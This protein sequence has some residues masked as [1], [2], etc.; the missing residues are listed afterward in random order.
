MK[1]ILIGRSPDNDIVIND[2]Y[3]SRRHCTLNIYDDGRVSIQDLGSKTG[4]YVNGKKI[5]TEYF[6]QPR[7]QVKIG[8][9]LLPW[10]TYVKTYGQ[11]LFS[12]SVTPGRTPAKKLHLF[13]KRR[14][15]TSAPN[16]N[17][18]YGAA[19]T[20]L[21]AAAA[22]F[23]F[24]FHPAYTFD[25]NFDSLN[26]EA[27]D[28][29]QTSDDGFVVTGYSVED[30]EGRYETKAFLAKTDKK[31]QTE[32]IRLYPESDEDREYNFHALARGNVKNEFLVGGE[33]TRLISNDELVTVKEKI[34]PVLFKVNNEGKTVWKKNFSS[35]SPGIVEGIL[36]VRDGYLIVILSEE[37][38]VV[39]KI[40][41]N[42]N[43]VWKKKSGPADF[44]LAGIKSPAKNT[45]MLLGTAHHSPY[46][47]LMDENGNKRWSKSFEKN[48]DGFMKDVIA[49]KNGFTL[50]GM[51]ETRQKSSQFMVLK[52]RPDGTLIKK[53][54]YGGEEEEF[55]AGIVRHRKG[56]IL[57]GTTKSEGEGKGDGIII[58]IDREGKEMWTKTYGGE[59]EDGFVKLIK[60]RDGN[61]AACGVNSSKNE[62]E[63]N[64]WLI[65]FNK[66]GEIKH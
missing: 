21:A 15:R 17:I 33:E 18:L 47:I 13:K 23:L 27:H 38:P 14:L 56:Y 60:T 37:K 51:R 48:H 16:R 44:Q 31:G 34:T 12:T 64:P 4:T 54:F 35:I 26:G 6:L 29:I 7:D 41:E 39:I 40:E 9:T 42:G 65:K 22:Y 28:L 66:K 24:F 3:V 57:G 53:Y 49:D 10:P 58:K 1:Q 61:Y 36:P 45:I 62:G 63:K 11:D 19:L 59:Y 43:T 5:S 46:V 2:K 32:W 30:E 20:V 55:P 52:I 25:K 50:L 8:Q